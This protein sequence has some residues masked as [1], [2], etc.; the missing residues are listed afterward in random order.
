[1]HGSFEVVNAYDEED[2][3]DGGWYEFPADAPEPVGPDAEH[4]LVL[5]DELVHVVEPGDGDCLHHDDDHEGG[6]GG[7][8]VQECDKKIAAIGD[9][10]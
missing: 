5:D 4:L 2:E 8:C 10:G 3:D 6:R 9:C 1:M 7:E